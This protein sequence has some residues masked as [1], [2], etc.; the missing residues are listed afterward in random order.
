MKNTDIKLPELPWHLMQIR[1]S[2]DDSIP[3]FERIDMD[4]TIHQDVSNDHCLYISPFN[5]FLNGQMF[6][7]GIQ[8]KIGGSPTKENLDETVSGM[9]G[10]IFS[11][12]S[13]DFV[14]PIGVD[15][16][17]MFEGSLCASAG[18]EGQFCGVRR[19]YEWTAGTY[20]LSLVKEETIMYKEAPHSWVCM[21]I[22][23][24]NGETT[25]I[26][27]LLF[28]GEKL[29]WQGNN[30]AFVEIYGFDNDKRNIPETSITFGRPKRG[31]ENIILNGLTAHQPISATT[32]PNAN[33]PNCAYV[34]SQDEDIT[35]HVTPYIRLQS[36]NEIYHIVLPNKIKGEF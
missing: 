14:T 24:N 35:V 1:W 34:T 8:T 27:R 20:T 13:H 21:Q 33:T 7:A 36:E 11:R 2:F 25:K 23:D 3:D 29:S 18:T 15:Y 12:W 6:Y 26:G 4:I 9:K 10:G 16:V 32:E 19:P 22:T 30:K 17:D 31:S 5:G 28:L